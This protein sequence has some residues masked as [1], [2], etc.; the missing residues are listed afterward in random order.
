[1]PDGSKNVLLLPAMGMAPMTAFSLPEIPTAVI[2]TG[3]PASMTPV[4]W[5]T[6]IIPKLAVRKPQLWDTTG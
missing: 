2:Q 1:M 3:F 4:M 6:S 5:L